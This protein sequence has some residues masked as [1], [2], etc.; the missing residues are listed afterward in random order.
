M[1]TAMV[2]NQKRRKENVNIHL[3]TRL[4]LDHNKAEI[5]KTI[6]VIL[7]DFPNI[8]LEELIKRALKSL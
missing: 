8:S 2:T 3:D 4:F 6:Q 7:K 5:E 1:K